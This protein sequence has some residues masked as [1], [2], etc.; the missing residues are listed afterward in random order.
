M[1]V[2]SVET[3]EDFFRGKSNEALVNEISWV[4]TKYI[5]TDSD[6]ELEEADNAL[7]AIKHVLRERLNITAE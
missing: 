4:V 7:K 1:N 6:S 3:Y 2:L 5:I